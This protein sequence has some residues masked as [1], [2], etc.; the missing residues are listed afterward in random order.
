MKRYRK[1]HLIILLFGVFSP[2]SSTTTNQQNK[3]IVKM[4]MKSFITIFLVML[5]GTIS[6]QPFPKLEEYPQ[7]PNEI[8][9]KNNIKSVIA[10]MPSYE[11]SQI[12]KVQFYYDKFGRD[13]SIY[14]DSSRFAFIKYLVNNRGQVISKRVY[15]AGINNFKLFEEYKI[16]YFKNKPLK[17]V[18]SNKI[19]GFSDTTFYF[20]NGLIKF[21]KQWDQKTFYKYDK[22]GKLLSIRNDTRPEALSNISSFSYDANGFLVKESLPQYRRIVYSYDSSGMLTTRNNQTISFD[23]SCHCGQWKSYSI[24]TYS[25]QK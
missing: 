19:Y 7:P 18:Y 12:H 24:I 14:E 1:I 10:V 15:I 23:T 25:Y 4:Y 16:D 17:E 22:T 8:I 13:T 11:D 2:S 21:V 6:S 3:F 9:I 5:F 20:P